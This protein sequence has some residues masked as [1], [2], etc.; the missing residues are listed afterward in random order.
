M[1]RQESE[2]KGVGVS[3]RPEDDFQELGWRLSSISMS[4]IRGRLSGL[5]VAF[6][7]FA[8]IISWFQE[9]LMRVLRVG[10]VPRH[11]SFI[12]D[13]NRRFAKRLNKPVKEGHRAGGATLIDI[14]LLC[15]K[16]RVTTV[17]AYAFSIEN[18]NRS[19]RE[20]GT[21]MDL[22]AYY[23][24]EFTARAT[25][26]K[27]EMYGIRMRVVGDVSLLSEALREKIRV[28]EE[29][30][31][32]G[33]EFTLYLA[34][35]YTSRNDIVH[36]MKLNIETKNNDLTRQT[37]IDETSLTENMY[38][39]Q[40]SDKCDLLIRTSGHTRLSDYMLWQVHENSIIEFVDCLWPDFNF[41]HLYWIVLK[42]S[43]YQTWQQALKLNEPTLV[44]HFLPKIKNSMPFDAMK[45]S[46][47]VAL[48]SLPAPPLAVSVD[49]K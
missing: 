7:P 26:H 30:T 8:R 21:L 41:W 49:H 38:F 16:L 39:D 17:S 23:I 5:N 15:K 32:N 24:D 11:L 33:T 37:R 36:S 2:L 28:A 42:W 45:R 43:F 14:L 48:D 27:D 1:K 44:S 25:D 18:F 12:M 19:P 31:K 9:F 4:E 10:P 20:V 40:F 3:K 22:L 46:K 47:R 35:P 29:L 6:H 34:L 13:G